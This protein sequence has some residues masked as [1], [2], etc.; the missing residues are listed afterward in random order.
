MDSRERPSDFH[1]QDQILIV[2]AVAQ[3]AGPFS[4]QRD[5][6][7]ERAYQIIET[8]SREQGLPPSELL[9]QAETR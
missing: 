5:P 3:W 6:R 1:A 7:E 9:R 8:I 2:E 4:N